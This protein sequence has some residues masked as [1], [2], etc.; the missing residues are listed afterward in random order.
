MSRILRS[1]RSLVAVVASLAMAG[2][3][4]G[5]LSG[6]ASVKPPEHGNIVSEYNAFVTQ[7]N[8]LP[9]SAGDMETSREYVTRGYDLAERSCVIYFARLKQLRNETTFISD[10]LVSLFA[11]GGII[12]G[13]AGAAAPVLV[14]LFAGAG[15]V[16]ST[17]QNFNSVYLL[18]E[19][20]DDLYPSINQS[21]ARFRAGHPADGSA[22]VVE[23][24]RMSTRCR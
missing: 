14:A 1:S 7:W 2:C 3:S 11:A 17:I 24:A 9:P 4:G 8:K 20:G 23:K 15:F 6:I 22:P 12:A 21:M 5:T 19:V 10:T 13:L 18:A 16:P